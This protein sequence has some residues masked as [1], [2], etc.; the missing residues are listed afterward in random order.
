MGWASRGHSDFLIA[1]GI[2]TAAGQRVTKL[3]QSGC[4]FLED[5][6]CTKGVVHGLQCRTPGFYPW[7]RKIPWRRKW[8]PT[9][10]FL[11]GK[12]HG[13]RSLVDYSPWDRKESDMTERLHYT[14]YY[15]KGVVLGREKCFKPS[16]WRPRPPHPLPRRHSS[17]YLLFYCLKNEFRCVPV[18]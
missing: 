13:Q 5:L 11:P 7:V 10:V 8:Q 9:P 2:V 4:S 15:T 14:L 12:S 18:F 3:G 1:E 17:H 6:N 16:L